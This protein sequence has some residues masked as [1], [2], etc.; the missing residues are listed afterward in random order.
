MIEL[1]A[2][3]R[4]IE[5]WLEQQFD[6]SKKPGSLDGHFSPE[7]ALV[8]QQELDALRKERRELAREQKAQ[9][10]TAE[11]KQEEKEKS[12]DREWSMIRIITKYLLAYACLD[13]AWQIV[14]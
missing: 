3:I 4:E 9:S 11:Q 7:E 12:R 10:K 8:K 14:C 5:T 13:Y 2:K 6:A 1:G